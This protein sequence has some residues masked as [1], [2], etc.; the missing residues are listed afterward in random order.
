[1]LS[2]PGAPSSYEEKRI[3][4]KRHMKKG[5]KTKAKVTHVPRFTPSYTHIPRCGLPLL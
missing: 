5:G 4:G 3:K 2:S 1:M